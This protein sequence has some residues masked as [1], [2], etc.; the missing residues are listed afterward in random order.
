MSDKHEV[1]T[2]CVCIKTEE[3]VCVQKHI[4]TNVLRTGLPIPEQDFYLHALCICG[5]GGCLCLQKNKSILLSIFPREKISM[6][7]KQNC[8]GVV[9][10]WTIRLGSEGESVWSNWCDL[11]C[12][13]SALLAVWLK[14]LPLH[15]V[16]VGNV[17]APLCHCV[18]IAVFLYRC[19]VTRLLSLWIAAKTGCRPCVFPASRRLHDWYNLTRCMTQF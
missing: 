16:T 9:D 18:G 4:K 1:S 17:A 6:S 14:T 2:W 3:V 8:V 15:Y 12:N 11:A 13:I 5:E 19:C 7:A 10:R